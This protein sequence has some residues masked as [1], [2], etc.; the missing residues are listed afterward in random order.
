MDIRFLGHAAFELSDGDT[1]ILIDPF[2]TGNP[3]AAAKVHVDDGIEVF[4]G[5]PMENGIAQDAGVID[6]DIE[7]AE[8]IDRAVYDSLGGLEVGHALEVGHRL[9]ACRSYFLDNVFGRRSRLPGAVEMS[10]EVVDDHLGALFSHQEH[11]FAADSASGP[12]DD[13]YF[14]F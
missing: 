3:K 13:R 10:P 8:I 12:G 9:A 4:P 1:R 6:D 11:F 5:H 7:L 2:L 14:A